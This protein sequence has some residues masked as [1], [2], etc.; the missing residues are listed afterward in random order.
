MDASQRERIRTDRLLLRPEEAAEMLSIGRS[1]LYELLKSG[2]VASLQIGRS[3]RISPDALDAFVS[4]LKA[5]AEPRLGD[6]GLGVTP[7]DSAEIT[8]DRGFGGTR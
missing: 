8:V 5:G 7:Q 6:Q 4:Q 2:A 3:R 1:R